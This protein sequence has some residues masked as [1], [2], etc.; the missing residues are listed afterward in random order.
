MRRLTKLLAVLAVLALITAACSNES[1][2]TTT[3]AAPTATTAAPTATTAGETTTTEAMAELVGITEEPCEGGNPDHGCIYLGTLT[4]ESGPFAGAAP[5]LF[6]GHQLFWAAV[7]EDGGIGDA[8][9]VAVPA[10]LKKDTGYTEEG[11]V[12]Q[13]SQIADQVAAVAQ[14]LGTPPTL[15]VMSDYERDHTVAAPMSW[16]SGYAFAEADGPGDFTGDQGRILEFGTNYCFE[17]MNAVDWATVAIPATGREFATA[18][19]AFIPNDYG[20]DYAAGVGIAAAA[21]GIDIAWQQLVIPASLGGDP[22]QTEAVTKI[23]AEPVDI[24]FLAMGPSE[25]AAIVGGAAQ[26]MGATVPLFIGAAPSWNVALLGS[27]AAPAFQ[28]G[29]FFQSSFLAGWDYETPGHAKMR[30]Y[31][32]GAGLPANDFF[33]AGWIGQYALKTVLEDAYAAGDLSKAGIEAAA[34]ALGEVDYEGMMPS[35]T[36]QGDPNEI[37]PRMSVMHQYSAEATTG[38]AVIANASTSDSGYF[39][40]PTAAG[41]T[42]TEACSA[43][44]A[45]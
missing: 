43:P 4:D 26:Q 15:A 23:V 3:T 41:F 37:F 14:S 2:E 35:R 24:V 27:P 32:E 33:G 9:D 34:K 31:V 22:T 5:A 11:M 6:G 30:A 21:N 44:E 45:G 42:Y 20:L 36:F 28:S 25:S 7:N 12:T 29:I 18:G 39:V 8:Y 17:A 16:W 10:D 1:A 40:G 13:Y 38:M 19:I